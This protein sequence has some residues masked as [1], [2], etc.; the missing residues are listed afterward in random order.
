MSL[1]DT[2]CHPGPEGARRE[3]QRTQRGPLFPLCR[4][5]YDLRRRTK[6]ALCKDA[7]Y[8]SN[9]CLSL[10]AK[11]ARGKLRLDKVC[12]GF[13]SHSFVGAVSGSSQVPA[14]LAD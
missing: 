11:M 8:R 7:A 13:P 12:L 9:I 6:A 4:V 10:H 14:A 1:L 3:S 5:K 2:I